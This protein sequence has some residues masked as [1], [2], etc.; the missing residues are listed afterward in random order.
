MNYFSGL[1]AKSTKICFNIVYSYDF[2]SC[3][4]TLCENLF[5]GS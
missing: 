2:K 1:L 5:E 3:Q 4:D